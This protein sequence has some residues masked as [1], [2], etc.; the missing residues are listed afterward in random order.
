MEVVNLVNASPTRVKTRYL[1]LH[2]FWIFKVS[3]LKDVKVFAPSSPEQINIPHV[4]FK[5]N[6]ICYL[7]SSYFRGTSQGKPLDA[8]TGRFLWA[9]ENSQKGWQRAWQAGDS[10]P[11][12]HMTL[13]T[14]SNLND[15]QGVKALLLLPALLMLISSTKVSHCRGEAR[16]TCNPVLKQMCQKMTYLIQNMGLW[17]TYPKGTPMCSGTVNDFSQSLDIYV[18]SDNQV[19]KVTSTRHWNIFQSCWLSLCS[20]DRQQST[21]KKQPT[22]YFV[23]KDNWA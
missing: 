7:P 3:F 6:C 13:Y 22:A 12:L 1:F 16:N 11:T 18:H 17:T 10:E 4:F 5:I 9:R 14:I 20:I 2:F 8:L 23:F 21:L 19:Q 15:L